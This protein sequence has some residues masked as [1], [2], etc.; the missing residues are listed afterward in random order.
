VIASEMEFVAQYWV[1]TES[2]EP[3]AW[4]G[5]SIVGP[6]MFSDSGL[7]R[8]YRILST[9]FSKGVPVGVGECWPEIVEADAHEAFNAIE[10]LR[11]HCST[12]MYHA[13]RVVQG[14]QARKQVTLLRLGLD[15]AE[16]AVDKPD[17]AKRISEK[18]SIA[19]LDVFAGME[20]DRPQTRDELVDDQLDRMDREQDSG[21]TLPWPKMQTACGPWMPGDLIGVTG[22]SGSGKSTLT[23]NLAMSLA[24]RGVPVIVFPTE[25]R[26]QWLSRAAATVSRVPQWI[27]EKGLWSKATDAQVRRH[28][29]VLEAMRTWPWEIVNRSNVTPAQLVAAV[30]TLRRTWPDER[31]VVLV[32]HMHRL[33]YGDEEADGE[34]GKATRM[35]K[36][37]AT[38]DR[39]G[40]VFVLLYQPKKPESDA[41]LYQPIHAN[42]IR[43]HSMVWNELDVHLSVFRAWI[44]R[45]PFA[46]TEWGT[47]AGAVTPDNEPKLTKPFAEGAQ[48]DEERMYMKPDKRRVGGEGR[49]FWLNFRQ[50]SGHVYEADHRRK[51][52]A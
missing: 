48:V 26:E 11:V 44:E 19:L 23:A 38:D 36:N 29:E 46:S 32:D 21:I 12:L 50:P 45:S 13:E 52:V 18:L 42:R 33:D 37:F 51:E 22:Y 17:R 7:G 25:M 39:A 24:E 31:V 9:R 49:T 43:G 6:E 4:K 3:V 2:G 14:W 40:L 30:R 10:H 1:A 16:K 5:Q 41:A 27:V 15:E 34:A 20:Q 47:Q 28:K 8:L 35:L